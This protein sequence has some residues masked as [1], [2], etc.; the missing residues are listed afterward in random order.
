MSGSKRIR[1]F[2]FAAIVSAV[3][4]AAP[5]S[6][7]HAST[8][9]NTVTLTSPMLQGTEPV[10]IY[11]ATA[12]LIPTLDPQRT[13][14]SLSVQ[15]VE[16]LFLGLTDVDPKTTQIR[17]E[18]ATKWEKNDKGDVWTFT[19][20]NDV[21]W[22]RYDPTTK[23][24][25]EVRKVV[26]GDFEYGIKRAC[27]PRLGSFYTPVAASV[28]KG[29]DV[30]SKIKPSQIKD[31]DFD[32][33]AVKAL[34]DTQLQI[35]TNGSLPFF[36]STTSMWMFRAVP[37]ETI[38]EF[39]DKW[40]EPGNIVSNG[41]YLIDTWDRNVSRVYVKN[42]LYPKDVENTYGGNVERLQTIVVKDASTIYSLYQNNEV[43]SS[44]IPRAELNSI[45]NDK[46]RSKEY[47][48]RTV[49]ATYYF[50]FMYDKP[51]FDNVHVRRAFSAAIDRKV[52]VSELAQGLGVPM[53]HFMPPGIRGA[54][55]IN[56][57]ALGQP[58]NPGF[59]PEYANA[60]MEAA[61]Y[62]DCEGFPSI[63]ILTYAGATD[64]A[65]FLQNQVQT[66]LGCD[67][68]LINVEEAEF[69]VL[70]KSIKP[71]VPTPQRPNMYTLGWNADYPDAHNW[72]RD[73]L[74]C[75]AENDFKRPC[76]DVDKKIDAADLETDPKKRDQLYREIEEAFFGKDGE[77]PMA[78]LYVGVEAGLVK[79]WYKGFFQTDG[80]F[81]G[82]HWDTRIIDQEAQL[83]ARAGKG[84]AQ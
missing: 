20:R 36:L 13:E 41:P 4:L 47:Y 48:Q 24:A 39:G 83:A 23:K 32:Q 67:A 70:L 43:D 37:K 61:G 15:P 68:S 6:A 8:G 73:V 53:A 75:N 5:L 57:V 2:L 45:R 72:M 51:P 40:I 69:S 1:G 33:I 71:D 50:G 9:D 17:A 54:V 52:F 80:L 42:P 26:A 27:D 56:E 60:E 63:T 77:F 7:V 49:L 64:W 38:A 30:V 31:S 82:D 44:G 84:S 3:V 58:D 21:P 62:K 29:C 22:V 55:A 11:G 28:I 81:G 19:L 34:S 74:H 12:S 10:T 46:E 78:P 79:P 66:N 25:T 35:T 14:D 59:D 76:T 18:M 16:N 65:E